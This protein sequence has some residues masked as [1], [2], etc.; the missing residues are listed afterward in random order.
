MAKR[1]SASYVRMPA[2]SRRSRSGGV[3]AGS[4]T[5]TRTTGRPSRVTWSVGDLPSCPQLPRARR[6]GLLD[7]EVGD[8]PA[9]AHEERAPVLEPSEEVHDG[10]ARL[11]AVRRLQDEPAERGHDSPH[12]L[13]FHLS[14]RPPRRRGADTSRRRVAPALNV[15]DVRAVFVVVA[16]AETHPD[17]VPARREAQRLL[18]APLAQLEE[19]QLP[20]DAAV[21]GL[22]R[23]P[24][25]VH[26]H[27]ERAALQAVLEADREKGRGRRL[28]GSRL[29]G[30]FGGAS[31]S[32]C[33]GLGGV[34]VAV[35]SGSG[36]GV[37]A[38]TAG[39]GDGRRR[40]PA[41]SEGLASERAGGATSS[42][43]GS[44]DVG[45]ALPSA[46]PSAGGVGSSSIGSGDGASAGEAVASGCGDGVAVGSTRARVVSSDHRPRASRPMRRQYVTSSGCAKKW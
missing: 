34:G 8:Q 4:P 18:H 46:R 5:S 17:L 31:V 20:S 30:R 44:G 6:V 33:A 23:H 27:L 45:G 35:G 21:E 10:D 26:P 9:V 3:S 43:S 24:L 25:A 19:E 42:G 13:H 1:T 16:R 32:A 41:G 29:R 40:A 22:L 11:D 7:V 37:G 38:R 36:V 15:A 28:A 2:F 12:L 14:V 39:S